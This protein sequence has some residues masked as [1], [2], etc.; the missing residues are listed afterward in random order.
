MKMLSSSSFYNS[1]T[2]TLTSKYLLVYIPISLV[3]LVKTSIVGVEVAVNVLAMGKR[4]I[5]ENYIDFFLSFLTC[6]KT[7]SG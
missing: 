4:K 7:S 3:L 5:K 2:T 1:V 6:D